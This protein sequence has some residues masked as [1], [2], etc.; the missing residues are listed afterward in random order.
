MNGIA[1]TVND[2]VVLNRRFDLLSEDD[3]S[4]PEALSARFE[5]Y[6]GSGA[7]DW[8]T[9]L[10]HA[11]VCLL[12]EAG[13]GKTRELRAKA[14]EL[15]TEGRFAVFAPLEALDRE[16]LSTVLSSADETALAAWLADGH[17]TGWFFLDA[18]DELKLTEGVLERALRRLAKSITGSAHRARIIVSSRPLDWRAKADRETFLAELPEPAPDVVRPPDPD[19]ALIAAIRAETGMGQSLRAD[20]E[21]ASSSETKFVAVALT[22]LDR[23]QVSAFARGE[24]LDD[25]APFVSALDE[26]RAW[27]FAR[28]PMDLIDLVANWT[29]NG[30]LGSRQDQ[31]RS[32]IAQKLK[33]P[34]DRPDSDILSENDAGD[35]AER[36]ALAMTLTRSQTLAA[37][38]APMTKGVLAP[39]SIL[40]SWTLKA[41]GALL[42][43]GLFDPATYSR[44]RFH[45]QSV[46]QY[47]AARRFHRLRQAGMS[48]KALMR[49]LVSRLYGQTVVLP[50]MR[51]IAAWLALWDVDVRRLLVTHEPQSLLAFGDPES[52][53]T[54][55]RSALLRSFVATFG[56][57]GWRG[58]NIP[59]DEVRRLAQPD[60]GPTVR[61]L[62]P[63]AD[64]PDAKDLLLEV[65]WQGR[66]SDCADLAESLALDVDAASDQ[67]AVAVE[68]LRAIDASDALTRIAARMRS[69]LSEWP[70]RARRQIAPYLYPTWL[71]A[72]ALLSIIRETPETKSVTG[73]FGWEMRQLVG[74]DLAEDEGARL[75]T[76]LAQL[77]WDGRD[78]ASPSHSLKSAFSYLAP[79]LAALCAAAPPSDVPDPTLLRA[80]EIANRFGERQIGMDEPRDALAAKFR[81]GQS[82]REPMFWVSLNLFDALPSSG[83]AWN[84]L[85]GVTMQRSLMGELVESDRPW[86]EASIPGL[87]GDSRLGVVLEGLLRLWN[88][89]GRPPSDITDLIA[90][91]GADPQLVEELRERTAPPAPRPAAQITEE[92]KWREERLRREA[93]E[94]RHL[95]DWKVWRATLTG[96]PDAAFRPDKLAHTLRNI[97][98]FLR[99]AAGLS[100]RYEV[101]NRDKV[102]DVFGEPVAVLASAHF[103]ASW[104]QVWPVLWSARSDR[105]STPQS[106]TRG[107]T[108]LASKASTVGWTRNLSAQDARLA[109][110]LALTELNGFGTM[111]EDLFTD[112]PSEV[113]AVL[114]WELSAE[115]AMPLSVTF[116]PALQYLGQASQALKSFLAPRILIA[117]ES[118][119]PLTGAAD[120]TEASHRLEQCL[121]LIAES[122]SSIERE[123][124]A[125]LA[126]AHVRDAP[127]DALALVWL[128]GLMRLDANAALVAAMDI[129]EQ[130]ASPWTHQQVIEMLAALFGR[131]GGGHGHDASPAIIARLTRLAFEVVREADD[132]HHDG[133]YTPGPRD[134]AEQAREALLSA[135][136]TRP[137]AEA[138]LEL[139][140]LIE[141]G[142]VTGRS[143]RLRF[144]LREKAGRDGEFSAFNPEAVLDLDI[145][146]EVPPHDRDGMFQ[147]MVDRLEDIEHEIG[148][149]DFSDWETLARI[150]LESEMRRSLGAK[151]EMTG[152]GAF[153]LTQE[154]EVIEAKRTDLRLASVRSPAKA[155]IEI[156]LSHKWTLAQM[157]KALSDQLQGQYLRHQDCR[158]GCLLITD[159]GRQKTWR[160]GAGPRLSFNGLIDHLRALAIA[161]VAA[162][163]TDVRIAVMGLGL[164]PANAD[165]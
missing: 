147:L 121:A 129:Y 158:A 57:G 50:S 130:A 151:L 79:A 110:G 165:V 152:R 18:V 111:L 156:K 91:A 159:N 136:L 96:D 144:L 36:L 74:R 133:V 114:G 84:R 26:H 37:P 106:W 70:A 77:I 6:S 61:A 7:V 55:T 65:I 38:D 30:E 80:I 100:A 33:E 21:E 124:A 108:G 83:D 161:Q 104:R 11:R 12:A 160:K 3:L 149:S 76:G 34:S 120:R 93:K 27:D 72:E 132:L 46:Q 148:H 109:T 49:L 2:Y 134:H 157:E 87:S 145:G 24:G 54:E 45:H 125:A 71:S 15:M 94:A 117:L 164:R 95:A 48:T 73:G 63:A 154:S 153:T 82:W 163:R 105:D 25:P 68:A 75:R 64:S 56:A 47:L 135:L 119:A 98:L 101:W 102:R 137:G 10:R 88:Q 39:A 28:R 62:W 32:N 9:L 59:L 52:L 141:E 142:A 51:P 107:L 8:D 113:D 103:A 131:Y 78:P 53:A 60:L 43:R 23:D 58:V 99:G 140:A 66:L 116:L 155:V 143:D 127:T 20:D 150:D 85:Y 35:G 123:T 162:S 16:P 69:H 22:P 17:A 42:R 19:E 126:E 44:V 13:S 122:G 31:H 138:A 89:R 139:L 4:R 81:P 146:L 67:R 118:W 92:K 86:L 40:P 97:Y 14:A 115:L 29:T 5:Q 1:D 90:F 112:W 41:R 128:K